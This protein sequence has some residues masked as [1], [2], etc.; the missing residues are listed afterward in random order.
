MDPVGGPAAEFALKVLA[1]NGRA[2]FYGLI[3]GLPDIKVSYANLLMQNQR[4]EGFRVAAWI[5]KHSP[6]QLGKIFGDLIG[7]LA[8]KQVLPVLEDV[9]P[10]GDFNTAIA[11]SVAPGKLGKVFLA[12]H[13]EQ[14][15]RH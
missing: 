6:E 3:S 12:P 15:S 14:V 8:S 7:L 4:I 11:K 13:P 1:M 2:L 10:F 9:L 5:S